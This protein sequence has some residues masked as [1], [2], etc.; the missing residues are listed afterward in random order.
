MVTPPAVEIRFVLPFRSNDQGTAAPSV[1]NR[2][3]IQLWETRSPGVRGGGRR[4]KYLGAPTT[5]T[6][7]G[8]ANR[9]AIMS[10]VAQ[11]FGPIPASKRLATMSIGLMS[12][13]SS[14]RTSG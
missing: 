8:S 3:W 11:C 7:M 2:Y 10:A 9:T 4:L 5:A 14:R 13:Q 12:T 1:V 6:F